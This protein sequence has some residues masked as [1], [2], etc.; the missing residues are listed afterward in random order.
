VA[1]KRV[2]DAQTAIK[3]EQE[4]IRNAE[5]GR[6]TSCEPE[7]PFEEMLNAQGDSLSD[8]ASSRDEE[9]WDDEEDDEDTEVGKL[10]E[11]DKPGWV[12]GAIS[13]TAQHCMK[14][15]REKHMGLDK[16]TSLGWG[17][18]AANFLEKD[19]KY[20]TVELIIAAVI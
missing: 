10:S 16:L 14:R 5:N 20:W 7:R 13:K 12:R 3:Q 1:R 19:M 2:E 18:M 8:L 15:L 11:D 6:G 4:D 17:D 9:D